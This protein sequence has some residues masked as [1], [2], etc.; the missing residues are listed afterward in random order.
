MSS[1]QE[2]PEN[3]LMR[4]KSIAEERL[5]QDIKFYQF[6]REQGYQQIE[7][8]DIKRSILEYYGGQSFLPKKPRAVNPYNIFSNSKKKEIAY[9]KELGIEQEEVTLTPQLLSEKYN[10]LSAEEKERVT[11]LTA[12][13]Q[14]E[15]EKAVPDQVPLKPR[16]AYKRMVWQMDYLNRTYGY[17]TVGVFLFK[18]RNHKRAL[19]FA[20]GEKLIKMDKRAFVRKVERIAHEKG[21]KRIIK[22]TGSPET[23]KKNNEELS[24]MKKTLRGMLNEQCKTSF[25]RMPWKRLVKAKELPNAVYCPKEIAVENWPLATFEENIVTKHDSLEKLRKSLDAIRFRT[26]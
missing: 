15:L 17:E 11:F 5:K 19:S 3:I 21:Y 10:G 6:C 4:V 12:E 25:T 13:K 26:Q 23:V 8:E 7:L 18:S 2:L 22:N 24:Y 16:E 14:A 20:T 9:D 1:I